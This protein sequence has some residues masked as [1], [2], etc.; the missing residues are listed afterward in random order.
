MPLLPGGAVPAI[1]GK[2]LSVIERALEI[3][4]ERGLPVPP[5]LPEAGPAPAAGGSK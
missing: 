5:P 2:R 1:Q 3:V 4:A